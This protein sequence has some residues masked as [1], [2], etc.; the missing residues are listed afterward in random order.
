MKYYIII[1]WRTNNFYYVQIIQVQLNIIMYTSYLLDKNHVNQFWKDGNGI[2]HLARR[3]GI[4]AV[5]N[6]MD[7]AVA[8]YRCDCFQTCLFC[9]QQRRLFATVYNLDEAKVRVSILKQ[10]CYRPICNYLNRPMILM[11][12]F[13]R[14]CCMFSFI[15]STVIF[16]AVIQFSLF[17][18][19]V[20]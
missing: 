20:A 19:Y 16:V 6:Y 13:L 4:T 1:G 15:P 14:R 9:S 18:C 7:R 12:A 5:K 3:L 2:M 11:K 17:N 8:Y 10:R